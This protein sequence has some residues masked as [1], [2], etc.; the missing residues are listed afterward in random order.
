M[1]FKARPKQFKGNISVDDIFS[2][3]LSEL[4]EEDNTRNIFLAKSNRSKF[5]VRVRMSSYAEN[6]CCVWVIVAAIY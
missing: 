1:T 3:Y 2:S 4:E 5:G 6:V